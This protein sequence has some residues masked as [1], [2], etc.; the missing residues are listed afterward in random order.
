MLQRS[1]VN[2][3]WNNFSNALAVSLWGNQTKEPECHV[4]R[5]WAFN[6]RRWAIES[7][8]NRCNHSKPLTAWFISRTLIMLFILNAIDLVLFLSHFSPLDFLSV[9]GRVHL[10]LCLSFYFEPSVFIHLYFSACITWTVPY[11]NF[12]GRF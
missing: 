9:V 1:E 12:P 4:S 3:V 5:L 7:C 11:M 2:L 6:A 8:K 10:Y